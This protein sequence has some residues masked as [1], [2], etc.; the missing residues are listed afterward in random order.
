MQQA[1]L[2]EKIFISPVWFLPFIAL[3]IGGWLLY[4]S[5]QEAG[6][7]ITIHFD[8]ASGITP[9]KTKVIYK[10][11]P[12]GLVKD[13]EIADGLEGVLLHVEIDKKA[14]KGLV[15]DTTFWVVRPVV[16]AGRISGL[17]TL[18]SGSYI[19][20]KAGRSTM[21]SRS[22]VG[23]TEPPPTDADVPGLHITLTTPKLYSLQR[24]SYIYSQNL[25]IG[26]VEKYTLENNGLITLQ[27]FIK[28]E[29]SHLVRKNTR[30]WNSSGLSVTGDLQTGMEVNMESLASLIY[31][32]INC[33]TPAQTAASLPAESGQNFTLYKDFADAEY[34][35]PM[36]L[37]LASGE[38]IIA[39]KTRVL[40][41]GLKAGVVKSLD[42]NDDSFHTVTASI[43]LDPRAEVILRQNTRF[44]VIRPQV[45][46]E[47]IKNLATLIS[48][49]YI[50]FQP[51]EGTPQNH[52]IVESKPMPIPTLRAGTHFSLQAKDSG[53][54]TI[55][56]PISFRKLVVGEITNISLAHDG[57]S[58]QTQ[59]L[60]YEPFDQLVHKNSIF[61]NVSG[62]Q[63]NASLSKFT[64]NLSSIRAMIAGGI[65]F[66]NPEGETDNE[67]AADPGTV[68]TLYDGYHE[69]FTHETR[70]Q[71]NGLM[72]HLQSDEP[73]DVRIGSPVSY[74]N[75]TV[76]EVM[77]IS[78][79][80]NNQL[81]NIDLLIYEK[82][83]DLVN[84]S[85]KFYKISGIK[86]EMSLQGL[87]LETGPLEAIISG[88]IAFITPQKKKP[89]KSGHRFH[90]YND[91]QEARNADNLHL[92]LHLHNAKGLN[93]HT[94]IR[95]QGIEIGHIINLRFDKDLEQVLADA[96][97]REEA[98]ELFRK[99][100]VLY[101]VG[102]RVSLS[103]IHNLE[104]MLSG[105]YITLHPGTGK[106][107]DEFTVLPTAPGRSET[108]AGLNI[109]LESSTLG[110]LKPG[111]PIYYRQVPVG[112]I[113]GYELSPTAQHVWISANIRPE[114]QH[115]VHTGTKFWNV[116]G[117]KV[118]GGVFSGMTVSTESMEALVA[119]GVS[120]ATPEDKKMGEPAKNND[121]FPLHVK[122]EAEWK[123]WAPALPARQLTAFDTKSPEDAG[124]GPRTEN[125]K[126][127][128]PPGEW[129]LQPE[130]RKTAQ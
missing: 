103:G 38:G 108:Y 78:L 7:D 27:V 4:T 6:V 118:S 48:G 85:S 127:G 16:S 45:S 34:G 100:S 43:L 58:I 87:T 39:G 70:L 17:E 112:L 13:V 95:Y 81:V 22:F 26:Q 57:K 2:K 28:P 99:D 86:A 5:I 102:P 3:C 119:G 50:T 53:S 121:H 83:R 55:G 61:W 77:G 79:A 113:T 72:L 129:P 96:V 125:S 31:G 33:A 91:S 88:G 104:T 66:A 14:K 41:R 44:W 111:R 109:I 24:G 49:A 76:G 63:I 56:A 122:A 21:P 40:F 69:A 84:G 54:L 116:S 130:Y 59:I 98:A 47:G 9:G 92:T 82:K 36:T 123:N 67:V 60:I 94:K 46:I 115:L 18:L 20:V 8:S 75:I 64:I 117:I 97:I 29:F 101:L 68:F 65:T 30:F 74:N 15:K 32:G 89:L 25:Q 114:Y 73:G 120:L 71:P 128:L 10:G 80:H 124:Q 90:L 126:N 12:V 19:A 42:I 23:L 105:S 62:V 93:S 51:G 37:Q 106:P 11:I 107:A 1:V 52:F 110:S 35:I